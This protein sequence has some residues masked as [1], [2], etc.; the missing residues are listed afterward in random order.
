[1]GIFLIKRR[2]HSGVRPPYQQRGVRDER[3]RDEKLARARK[4]ESERGREGPVAVPDPES[5]VQR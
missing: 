5:R 2:P 3:I 4:K 1:M